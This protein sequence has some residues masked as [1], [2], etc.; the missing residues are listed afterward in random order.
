ME[1]KLTLYSICSSFFKDWLVCV[2]KPFYYF[3]NGVPNIPTAPVPLLV[4]YTIT[5]CGSRSEWICIIL[6]IWIRMRMRMRNA[7]AYADA[8]E[9]AGRGADRVRV[10]CRA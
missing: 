7:Y 1:E 9:G 4:T 3:V 8:D 6:E 5:A 2:E 10:R